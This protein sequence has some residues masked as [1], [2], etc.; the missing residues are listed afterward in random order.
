LSNSFAFPSSFGL[1]RRVDRLTEA[2]VSK[3]IAVPIFR[4][5]A[6][7]EAFRHQNRH[8]RGI[9]LLSFITFRK[10]QLSISSQNEM[11]TC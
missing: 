5:K 4:A 10:H 8:R 3:K 7:P 11:S 6:L 1:S 2:N 9:I